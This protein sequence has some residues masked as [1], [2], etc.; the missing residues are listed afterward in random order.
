[1]ET[2]GVSQ[3]QAYELTEERRKQTKAEQDAER[4]AE[5][6][7]ILQQFPD[8]SQRD[9]ERQLKASGH[10]RTHRKYTKQIVEKNRCA[11]IAPDNI[12]VNCPVQ[13]ARSS[14]TEP[15]RDILSEVDA[16]FDR[17]GA[18][19]T[20][21]PIT[22][23]SKLSRDAVI[24][25]LKY[26]KATHNDNGAKLLRDILKKRDKSGS[27]AAQAHPRMTAERTAELLL[28]G[29]HPDGT[30]IRER[31]PQ[32]STA[33]VSQLPAHLRELC[34]PIEIPDHLR[35]GYLP[36]NIPESLQ[37]YVYPQPTP[38][39]VFATAESYQQYIEAQRA[40]ELNAYKN[41]AYRQYQA[42]NDILTIARSLHV[43]HIIIQHWLQAAQAF[44]EEHPRGQ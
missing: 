17:D 10:K 13:N 33:D 8:T 23:Y 25:E 40:E 28:T 39:H 6:A 19:H 36:I 12:Y 42:G 22:A 20:P 16:F 11:Q 26:C 21:V 3:R 9:I 38:S 32:T 2:K 44:D 31:E 35:E 1:M 18:L 7:R 4:D 14:D 27:W 43:N 15:S 37:K 5:I 29:I 30:P 41:E 24:T 34:K